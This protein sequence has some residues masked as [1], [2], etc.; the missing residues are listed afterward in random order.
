ME[1]P[2]PLVDLLSNF[3][4]RFQQS[5]KKTSKILIQHEWPTRNQRLFPF[6]N[7]FP[8]QTPRWKKS[9]FRI[10]ELLLI[11]S[12]NIVETQ[13]RRDGHLLR[14]ALRST[15][16]ARR[17]LGSVPPSPSSPLPPSLTVTFQRPGH[18]YHRRFITNLQRCFKSGTRAYRRGC[19]SGRRV[20]RQGSGR[21]SCLLMAYS[22]SNV[23]APQ[24]PYVFWLR[25]KKPRISSKPRA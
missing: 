25:L 14:D 16:I 20:A 22:C 18:P 11:I 1:I 10:A 4:H 15:V 3:H 7:Y 24:C 21:W 5:K 6:Q 2:V 17:Y 9:S 19:G 8:I 13:R 23:V 12:S